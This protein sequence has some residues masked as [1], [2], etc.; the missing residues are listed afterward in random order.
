MS[1]LATSSI[2]PVPSIAGA[3][4]VP[5]ATRA[6][7]PSTVHGPRA[8]LRQNLFGSWA[9]SIATI[10]FGVLIIRAVY[11]MFDWGIVHAV[12]SVPDGANGQPDT[13]ACRAAQG[14]GACWAVLGEKYRFILFGR[15]PYDLQ[16]RPAIVIVLFIS[17][18][19]L[20]AWR[21]F[22]RKE[23]LLIWVATLV[24]IGFLMWGGILGLQY[25]PQDSGA[26]CRSP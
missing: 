9:S 19:G 7:P 14:I 20:S 8:W 13:S 10:V 24:V 16:W 11:G 18:Y 22:W 1:Q 21:R 4:A 6:R 3:P 15:F 5:A 25:V 26:A 2:D 23:L 12:W 17:L